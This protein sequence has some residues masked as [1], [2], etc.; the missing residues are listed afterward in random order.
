MA[1]PRLREVRPEESLWRV[2]RQADPFRPR[3]GDPNE[4]QRPRAGFRFDSQRGDYGVLYFGASL[5]CCFA[6]VLQD[7]SPS[8]KVRAAVDADAHAQGLRLAGVVGADWRH[9]RVAALAT[10]TDGRPFIDVEHPE[11]HAV[12]TE[13]LAVAL[14]TLNVERLNVSSVRGDDRRVT[15]TISQWIHD[16][17][18]PRETRRY[19]GMRYLS[20]INTEWECWCLFAD[21]YLEPGIQNPIPREM[22]ELQAAADLLS[23]LVY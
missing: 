19:A 10:V 2:A 9:A 21:C 14:A 20:K 13:E 8:A 15:R 23:L 11:T 18:D 12:L 4:L 3:V 7:F 16:Q 22:P 6:E 17:V 1:Q 5:T